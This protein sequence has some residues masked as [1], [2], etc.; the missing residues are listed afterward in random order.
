MTRHLSLQ[1]RSRC[2]PILNTDSSL[3]F[4]QRE[5]LIATS[6]FLVQRSFETDVDFSSDYFYLYSAVISNGEIYVHANNNLY[7]L[8]FPKLVLVTEFKS[9]QFQP[10]FTFNNIL[11]GQ[12]E[13][14]L[15]SLLNN[16]FSPVRPIIDGFYVSFCENVV[17]V[18]PRTSV[19]TVKN[20][21]SEE[22]V[23]VLSRK[24]AFF[25]FGQ[26]GVIVFSD[27]SEKAFQIYDF[28]NQV[29]VESK[30]GS[31]GYSKIKNALV[32]GPTGIS[33]AENVL[34]EIFHINYSRQVHQIIRSYLQKQIDTHGKLRQQFELI[35][36]ESNLK[37]TEVKLKDVLTIGKGAVKA[38]PFKTNE[39]KPIAKDSKIDPKI[40]IKSPMKQLK[41]IQNDLKV[42]TFTTNALNSADNINN[43]LQQLDTI[44]TDLQ[45]IGY[46]MFAHRQAQFAALCNIKCMIQQ[47]YVYQPSQPENILDQIEEKMQY[48]SFNYELNSLVFNQQT[49]NSLKYFLIN[50]LNAKIEN[51]NLHIHRAL[52]RIEAKSD[53]DLNNEI[54]FLSDQQ[55]A[56]NNFVSNILYQ[57]QLKSSGF[58]QNSENSNQKHNINLTD[59]TQQK[60]QLNSTTSIQAPEI[61]EPDG[62]QNI[63]EIPQYIEDGVEEVAKEETKEYDIKE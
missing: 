8:Q 23:L 37:Q 54:N 22:K 1:E 4:G 29:I 18:R 17:F 53:I 6:N 62:E 55:R 44:N 60:D 15:Y 36:N 50:E 41:N 9:T 47:S 39:P 28:I 45:N 63:I 16:K 57:V 46:Q 21:F 58:T 27:A 43:Q 13:N 25:A 40:E 5:I 32:H 26:G 11:Y 49:Q 59:D 10:I 31:L 51:P 33:L 20:D 3:Y 38:M 30:N 24:S 2:V 34:S 14:S 12:T 56:H 35:T 7:Q 19:S 42:Q 61:M 52:D 48:D